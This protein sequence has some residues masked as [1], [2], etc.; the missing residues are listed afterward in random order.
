MSETLHKTPLHALH[1]EL[2]ARMVPFA[3]YDMPVQYPLGVLKEHLH[4]R[5]QA[6]L[7]DVSHMGQIILRGNDAARALE[8]LVPV[9]IVDLPVGMQRYAMFTNAEG[10]ILDDLM[11]ANLGD[12][13]L[14]LVVNAACKDQDLAHLRKHIG[15][16]CEIQPL[17][18]QRALLALQGPAAVKVLERLA[19]EVA[20]MTFMQF[21]PVSLLG[22]DC[23]V[24]RSGY[25]GEDG[26]EISV[27][28]AAAEALA[29][30]LLAEPEVQPIGLGARDSL[31]LEAGLCL[32]GHD[33][34]TTTTPIEAS[35]LWAISKV[36]RADGTRAGGF[37]G[38]DTVFAQQQAGVARKRVGLLPQERTPVREGAQI[39]DQAGKV[40]GE[41][42]SGGFGPTL[43]APV[44][45]GYVDTEHAALDTA[46][47]AVVRGKQVALKVSKMP[48]VAQ[49]YYRG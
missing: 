7:F 18:E 22:N 13:T 33:M 32:Y 1:L 34:D 14:F 30:R 46:L 27:P 2:G 49:R 37:P 8:T 5:E 16:R 15:D 25:T 31:R 39:V 23:F 36:R 11:V 41:V 9:D 42:C 17:F 29:R 10:G 6:G 48:F 40:V 19:P 21:R 28:A 24:S 4:T 45:M 12:D 26:Y 35:L 43:G 47:F 20:G 44:A 3:G 38:A